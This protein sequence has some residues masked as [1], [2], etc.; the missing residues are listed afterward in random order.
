M[1]VFYLWCI[2]HWSSFARHLYLFVR[3]SSP[4]CLSFL[5]RFSV[6]CLP[7]TSHCCDQITQGGG[8]VRHRPRPR[9]RCTLPS[10]LSPSQSVLMFRPFVSALSPWVSCV[11]PSHTYSPLLAGGSGH[12]RPAALSWNVTTPVPDAFLPL[13]LTPVL[14]ILIQKQN[15][16]S[17][18]RQTSSWRNLRD[19][20][21]PVGGR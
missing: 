14:A 19:R 18:R 1:S 11:L 20:S 10:V 16:V 8:D 15:S 2:R 21:R 12:R 9:P 4:V 5:R 3:I 13:L 7:V 6:I 17:E